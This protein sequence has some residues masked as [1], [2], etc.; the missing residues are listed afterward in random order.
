MMDITIYFNLFCVKNVPSEPECNSFI[1][2]S[3]K[4]V[5]KVIN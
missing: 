3:E 2:L 1:T 5:S 4:S